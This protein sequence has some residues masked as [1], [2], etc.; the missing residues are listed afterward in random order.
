MFKPP[1]CDRGVNS[2][3]SQI[4]KTSD[5]TVDVIGNVNGIDGSVFAEGLFIIGPVEMLSGIK[6]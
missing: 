1:Y 6:I 2:D 5:Q 3:S 4:I